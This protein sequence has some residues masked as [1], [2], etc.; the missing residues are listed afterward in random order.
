MDFLINIA[1]IDDP[2]CQRI[3][4]QLEEGKAQEFHLRDD[5]MLTHFKQVCMPRGKG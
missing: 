2:E 4:Q 5:G 3:K 1:Q